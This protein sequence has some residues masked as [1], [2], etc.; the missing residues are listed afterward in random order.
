[1]KFSRANNSLKMGKFS[2]F[3]V[4]VISENLHILT[5][6]LPENISYKSLS[7]VNINTNI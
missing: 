4:P 7:R 3:S 5:R 6:L 1:M 2:K